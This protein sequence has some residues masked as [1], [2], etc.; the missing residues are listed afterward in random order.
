MWSIHFCMNTDHDWASS[1]T[2]A[3]AAAPASATA[4]W[5]PNVSKKRVDRPPHAR[6]VDA[7]QSRS[8]SATSS[9]GVRLG[10]H[11]VHQRQQHRFLGREVEVERRPGQARALGQV[12]DGDVGERP[13]L[14]QPL[15]GRQDRGLAVVARRAGGAA[16]AARA[17]GL[18]VVTSPTLRHVEFIDRL[19]TYSTPC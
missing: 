15:G 13:L 4:R 14:E 10:D 16:A 8:P 9:G 1:G 12:V 5:A 17:G 7:W 19:L 2:L 6:A 11:A 3:R 18:V